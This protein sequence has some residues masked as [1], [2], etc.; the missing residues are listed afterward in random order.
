MITQEELLAMLNDLES[1]RVERT[2][3]VKD[4]KKFGEAICAFANDLPRHEKPGYLIIGVD[5]NGRPTGLTITDQLLTNLGEF[6]TNG[7]IVPPPSMNV[8]KFALPEGDVAVVEV[9]PSQNPPVRY[10]QHV[11]IRV[12]PRQGDA[13]E[14][15]ERRL[16]EKRSHFARSF[17]T[18]PCYGSSINDMS[19]EI[20]KINYLPLAVDEETLAE[21]H[22]ELEQQLASL[23][24]YDLREN[25]P[26]NAGILLFGKNPLYYLP[27]AYIQYVQWAG[28]GM[29]SEV[30]AEKQFSGDLITQL[31]NIDSFIQTHIIREK[32]VATESVLQ[33]NLVANYPFKAIRELLMNA[34]LHRDYQSHM[35]VRLYEFSDRIEISNPGGLYGSASP[36]NFPRINDYR[37]PNLAEVLK[38]LGYINKFNRGVVVAR[39]E[40]K[41]NQNP[42]PEFELMDRNYFNVKIFARQI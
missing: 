10:R 2:Q 1:D 31:R 9:F 22:R 27:G 3:S 36:E 24:F 26:T 28:G 32:P 42:D 37:N 25:L 13:N 7:S 34:I 29:E 38:T 5:N 15:E 41:K 33:E 8:Q 35:P 16:S 18:T 14:Q 40:L 17:D 30:L 39:A 6:R 11:C 23:K 12:G 20:F 21:N 19:I 4:E